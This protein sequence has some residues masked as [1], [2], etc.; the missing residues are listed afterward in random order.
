MSTLSGEKYKNAECLPWVVKSILSSSSQNQNLLLL[1]L[2]YNIYYKS[3]QILET[4][5]GKQQKKSL[6]QIASILENRIYPL[7]RHLTTNLM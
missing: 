5:I 6:T 1:A 7:V 3:L 2:L 4:K